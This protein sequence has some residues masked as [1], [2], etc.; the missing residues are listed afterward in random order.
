MMGPRNCP[1]AATGRVEVGSPS[2]ALCTLW[3]GTCSCLDQMGAILGQWKAVP[4]ANEVAVGLRGDT[5]VSLIELFFRKK[6]RGHRS[7]CMAFSGDMDL[8]ETGHIIERL[9]CRRGPEEPQ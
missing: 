6:N 3:L 8:R 1:V 7:L 4:F 9:N 2:K 5:L